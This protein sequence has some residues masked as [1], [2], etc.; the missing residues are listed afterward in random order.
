MDALF[1]PIS[2]PSLFSQSQSFPSLFAIF[3][4]GD[5]DQPSVLPAHSQ[6][7]ITRIPIFGLF[8]FP[9]P[10]PPLSQGLLDLDPEPSLLSPWHRGMA[11]LQWKCPWG[12]WVQ[13]LLL[14]PTRR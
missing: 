9:L 11:S 2:N 12:C 3:S 13:V 1:P 4:L 14:C 5:K 6:H 8:F 7:G 10:F